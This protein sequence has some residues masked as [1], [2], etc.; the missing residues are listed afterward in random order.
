[1]EGNSRPFSSCLGT[2]LQSHLQGWS[3]QREVGARNTAG[4]SHPGG[5]VGGTDIL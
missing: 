4:C 5:A 3:F 2:S 1:M